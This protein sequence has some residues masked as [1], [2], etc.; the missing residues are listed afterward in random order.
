MG[1]N[2]WVS[3]LDLCENIVNHSGHINERLRRGLPS[4]NGLVWASVFTH[5]CFCNSTSAVR[6]IYLNIALYFRSRSGSL[7]ASKQ[8][9]VTVMSQDAEPE[10]KSWGAGGKDRLVFSCQ[11]QYYNGLLPTT[12]GSDFNTKLVRA[13]KDRPKLYYFYIKWCVVVLMI[14]V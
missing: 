3:F 6:I 2:S 1:M 12:K 4:L 13:N 10:E 5:R 8:E 7:Q 14:M 11:A 9:K